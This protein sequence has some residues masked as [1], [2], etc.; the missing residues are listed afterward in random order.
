GRL[1][2]A[3][4]HACGAPARFPGRRRRPRRDCEVRPLPVHV[5]RRRT[6]AAAARDAVW[7]HAHSCA[8]PAGVSRSARRL[9]HVHRA[10]ARRRGRRHDRRDAGHPRLAAAR[11][12]GCGGESGA[13]ERASRNRSPQCGG[14]PRQARIRPSE[15]A[16][17]T[18]SSYWSRRSLLR[19]FG[20]AGGAALASELPGADAQP[21]PTRRRR[22]A[23]GVNL[24]GADFGKLPGMHGREYLYPTRQNVDYYRGLGFSLVRLTF[25]WERLQPQPEGPFAQDE[26]ARLV[27]IVRYA[28][29]TGLEVILDPH[30]YAKRRI[31]QDG[32]SAD[33]LIGSAAVPASAFHDFWAR[34]AAVFRDDERVVLGLMNEP[35]GIDAEPWLQIVNGTLARIRAA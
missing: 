27:N 34:L 1:R 22:P 10:L 28:T 16:P 3:V 7:R 24:A 33:H 18:L 25:K 19:A 31:A 32:W 2:C 17:M 30:N 6:R 15:I 4:A 12:Q 11:R 20:A 21:A 9:R 13:L 14:L 23:G 29:S 35:T 5:T 26:Q 8:G